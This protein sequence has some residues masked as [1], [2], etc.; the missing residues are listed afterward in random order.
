M[1]TSSQESKAQ[2]TAHAMSGLLGRASFEESYGRNLTLLSQRTIGNQAM[3]QT[4]FEDARVGLISVA[5]TRLGHDFSQIP[6]HP[7]EARGIQTKLSVNKPGDEYEHEADRVADQVVRN[8]GEK[9]QPVQ[10]GHVKTDASPGIQNQLGSTSY[11][12]DPAVRVFME[13]RFG[14][15]FSHVRVHI[16]SRAA[17]ST[18]ALQARAFTLGRDIFFDTGQYQPADPGGRRLIAHELTHTLQQGWG[19]RAGPQQTIQR[20]GHTGRNVLNLVPVGRLRPVGDASPQYIYQEGHSNTYVDDAGL[21]WE[22]L[23]NWMSRYHQ[24]EGHEDSPHPYPNKK[25]THRDSSGGSSEAIMRPDGTFITT[26]PLQGTYNYSHPEGIL[27]NIGHF[28]Q[29]MLPH[30]FNDE[31]ENVQGRDPRTT[32]NPDTFSERYQQQVAPIG[33]AE[34]TNVTD[35]VDRQITTQTG[36]VW[37]SH[38]SGRVLALATVT[39]GRLTFRRF[40]DSDLRDDALRRA[41]AVQPRGI[42]TIPWG[43]PA[44]FGLPRSV[45]PTVARP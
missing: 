25:F 26:G 14:H 39:N 4:D 35:P 15:D 16:D 29:D 42:Q 32:L 43:P 9:I 28:F 11:S 24:P 2:K 13:P 40:I 18:Q 30:Y 41:R 31:Y 34:T 7:P 3:H 8:P 36:V 38:S 44:I 12:L 19:G 23:P 6:I 33:P 10:S 21:Q 20:Q 17:Q 5:S 1:S 27:G 22:L 37:L 45:P